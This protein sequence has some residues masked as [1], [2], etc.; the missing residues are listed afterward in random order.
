MCRGQ[1][2][3]RFFTIRS[4]PPDPRCVSE[5]VNESFHSL[6]PRMCLP[7][8]DG[9]HASSR[10]HGWRGNCSKDLCFHRGH[11]VPPFRSEGTIAKL[12]NSLLL[13]VTVEQ[14]IIIAC[15]SDETAVVLRCV[16][17]TFLAKASLPLGWKRE[18]M[19][20]RGAV[21]GALIT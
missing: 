18:T 19:Q 6:E 2:R 12:Y 3:R 4:R 5:D 15:Y 13:S 20:H 8:C 7:A 9:T 21:A 10:D 14:N 1:C 17:R 11:R 16:R